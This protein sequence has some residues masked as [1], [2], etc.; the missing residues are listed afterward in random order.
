M[1]P[2][3]LRLQT[4][5]KLA[6]PTG[7]PVLLPPLLGEIPPQHRPEPRAEQAASGPN[8]LAAAVQVASGGPGKS[9]PNMFDC[10][11]QLVASTGFQSHQI[12]H[13]PLRPKDLAGCGQ[14]AP[15]CGGMSCCVICVI[16]RALPFV[17]ISNTLSMT[18]R[19]RSCRPSCKGC[20]QGGKGRKKGG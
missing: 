1:T 11:A 6:R 12:A 18:C 10:T 14:C 2:R 7:P 15:N 16:G 17:L 3:I 4:N 8:L 13:P 5:E 9:S 20:G 19:T